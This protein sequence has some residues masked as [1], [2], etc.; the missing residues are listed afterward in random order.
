MGE[1]ECIPNLGLGCGKLDSAGDFGL[2]AERV[3]LLVCFVVAVVLMEV[4]WV[5]GE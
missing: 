5:V 2:P 1:E 3:V 4:G